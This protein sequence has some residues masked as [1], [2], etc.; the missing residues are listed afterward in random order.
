M[1]AGLVGCD[2]LFVSEFTSRPSSLFTTSVASDGFVA[3]VQTPQRSG[4]LI[5]GDTVVIRHPDEASSRAGVRRPS[6]SST[7]GTEGSVRGQCRWRRPL[8]RMS[9]SLLVCPVT[10]FDAAE[11]KATWRVGED[12][13][14]VESAVVALGPMRIDRH[15]PG[16]HALVGPAR[17]LPWICWSRHG[18]GW[19]PRRCGRLAHRLGGSIDRDLA[20]ED[21]RVGRPSSSRG[22]LWSYSG[23]WERDEV[24]L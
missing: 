20:G 23:W 10:R 3:M 2:G 9:F 17:T 4:A 12:V 11:T 16:S 24:W 13:R 21:S 8:T 14:V 5:S 7:R 6:R 15:A 22:M 19:L 1:T 18:S